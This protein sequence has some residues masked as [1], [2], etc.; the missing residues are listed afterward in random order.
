M[1]PTGLASRHRT[2]KYSVLTLFQIVVLVELY[3]CFPS[4]GGRVGWW[5]LNL[6]GL[7]EWLD[8]ASV[9]WKSDFMSLVTSSSEEVQLDFESGF[10]EE[11]EDRKLVVSNAISCRTAHLELLPS[12]WN[13]GSRDFESQGAKQTPTDTRV[14]SE[15]GHITPFVY[16]FVS[17]RVS[18]DLKS[19]R[20]QVVHH[21][22]RPPCMICSHTQKDVRF[23]VGHG[24]QEKHIA[25]YRMIA[26][27]Q[28]VQVSYAK[29]S[30]DNIII[31]Y[32]DD[33][34]SSCMISSHARFDISHDFRSWRFVVLHD[35][36]SCRFLCRAR[37]DFGSYLSHRV[38]SGHTISRHADLQSDKIYSP[39]RFRVMLDL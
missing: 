15:S 14:I 23:G 38:I 11:D 21:Q 13:T 35:F 10:P 37:Y 7:N 29:N 17:H 27:F 16:D 24:F 32:H 28:I 9:L 19:T 22:R 26:R 12:I 1:Q 20:F 8:R 30:P 39:A 2:A 36:R 25:F 18:W 31:S 6:Q 34:R 33:L 5:A 4:C 3:E